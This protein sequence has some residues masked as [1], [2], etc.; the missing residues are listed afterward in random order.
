[1]STLCIESEGTRTRI[2]G[3]RNEYSLATGGIEE[4]PVI[5]EFTEVDYLKL[6]VRFIHELIR[7]TIFATD[8]DSSR[9]SLGGVLFLPVDTKF[10]G[11]A[12]DG[13]RL[14][15]QEGALE[16]E[17]NP[18]IP[19]GD[20]IVPVRS[21]QILDRSLTDPDETVH[22]AIR[23]GNLLVRAGRFT[24]YTRMLEGRFPQWDRIMPDETQLTRID[25]P[26]GGF[27]TAV[28]QAAIV[29]DE[30]HPG[31]GFDFA[32]GK[33]TLKACAAET[34]E[35]HI[36]TPVAYDGPRITVSLDPKFLMDFL[37][38]LNQDSQ[39]TFCVKDAETP[40]VLHTDDGY[41][42]VVMPLS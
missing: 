2:S 16:R 14:A 38:V 17:G 42:C 25:L 37:R 41:S 12:T 39:I 26:V 33:V 29:T 19:Q 9:Y 40:I 5:A 18:V 11:V 20:S 30:T 28:R 6:P 21:L 10:L 8:P 36:E 13:R 23:N 27:H 1:D 35:S 15:M 3:E 34:G 7:R 22:L 31:V 32:E 4:F 24:M